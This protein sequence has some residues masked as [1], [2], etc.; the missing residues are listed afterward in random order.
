MRDDRAQRRQHDLAALGEGGLDAVED[1]GD[2]LLAEAGQD[3]PAGPVG[4]RGRGAAPE[5]RQ[6]RAAG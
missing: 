5:A 2:Q 4:Q 3:N 1:F 6:F